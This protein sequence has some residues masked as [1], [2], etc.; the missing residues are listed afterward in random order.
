M[1]EGWKQLRDRPEAERA[2]ISAGLVIKIRET[3]RD[4]MVSHAVAANSPDRRERKAAKKASR[5][6]LDDLLDMLK[7]TGLTEFEA[8]SLALGAYERASSQHPPIT[9]ID[10]LEVI[11]NDASTQIL[12]DLDARGCLNLSEALAFMR[13]QGDG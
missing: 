6:Q 7:A 8:R 5:S 10:S 11:A 2:R 13:S 9:D 12:N 4:H 1:S 3:V